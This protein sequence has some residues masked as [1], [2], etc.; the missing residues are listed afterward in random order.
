[1]KQNTKKVIVLLFSILTVGTMV[2]AVLPFG[3]QLVSADHDPPPPPPTIPW[4]TSWD[5]PADCR[6]DPV[7]QP[8]GENY[9]D[10]IGISGCD[11]AN[12]YAV[13]YYFDSSYAYFRE[14]VYGYPLQWPSGKFQQKAW[15]VLFDLPAVGD[16]EYL[17]S[18]NGVEEE[19][20]LWENT[21]SQPVE[22]SPILNDPAENIVWSGSTGTY[23]RV[24]PAGSWNY[25]VDW[26]IPLD[27]LPSGIN[28]NT[29]MYFTTSS[30][31][32]NFNKDYLDCYGYPVSE[33]NPPLEQACGLDIVLAMDESLSIDS[34]EFGQM[35]TAFMDFVNALL[36]DTPTEFALVDFGTNAVVRQGFT[37]NATLINNAIN[38]PKMG[39]IQYTNWE[40]ALIAAHN[41]FPNRDK[42]D[43]IIFASDGNPTAYGSGSSQGYDMSGVLALPPAIA[44]ANDIK[45]D[46]I[47]ILTI[48]IGDEL[49]VT[50]LIAIS[51]ADAV[52][53]T[54]FEELADELAEIA[55]ELCG[56]TV[57]VH[58]V[59]DNDCSLETTGDQTTEGDDV[60]GLSLIHI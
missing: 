15:V 2:L 28:K 14:R 11:A 46:G 7:D 34:T 29:T 10:L 54:N 39:G 47:R 3:G 38:Q 23:A 9:L 26:A 36:P 1:M 51:S 13:Y 12:E 44:A 19:V 56:G 24:V 5:Y 53:T 31:A 60:A 50:N 30:D 20:Q 58:K 37:D 59:I 33:P 40:Q 22:W 52:Y 48:G 27:Q 35:Q 43:L 42:P 49:N 8:W 57:S 55:I 18:I 17:L 6:C 4:P 32:N 45:N 25:F 16:Y 21:D 41:L